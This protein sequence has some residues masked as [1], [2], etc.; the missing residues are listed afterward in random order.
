MSISSVQSQT[1]DSPISLPE[2]TRRL[3]AAELGALDLQLQT[4]SDRVRVIR[5]LLGM[6]DRRLVRVYAGCSENT[7][8]PP[9]TVISMIRA[10][11]GFESNIWRSFVA[12]IALAGGGASL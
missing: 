2:T 8:Q 4:L 1:I 11:K 12:V 5:R 10:S 7:D 9:V 6:S 3:L